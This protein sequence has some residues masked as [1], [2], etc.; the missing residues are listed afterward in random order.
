MA[1]RIVPHLNEHEAQVEAFNQRIRAGGRDEGFYVR[2]DLEWI[3]P[4]PGARAWREF[5]VAIDDEQAVRGAFALKPQDWLIKGELKTVTDWQ[6]PV[7]EGIVDPRF[8]AVGLRMLRHMVKAR[9]LLYSQGHG[10]DDGAVVQ[11]LKEMGWPLHPMPFCFLVV[12]PRA[13]LR[14]NRFLRKDPRKAMALD[15][16]AFSG[17]GSLGLRALH[18]ALRTRAGH[19]LGLRPRYAVEPSFGPWADEVWE[20]NRGR[21]TALAVRDAEM[22][23]RL[24]PPGGWPAGERLRVERDG[25]TIGWA[26][27]LHQRMKD[28]PRFGN[29]HVGNVT[30]MFAAPE[31]AP[32]VVAAAVDHLRKK[33]VEFIYSNVSH[34]GWA[35]GFEANGFVVLPA[36]RLF[37]MAPPLKEAL[38]PLAET[39]QGLHL[40]N[41][42]GHGPQ[43]FK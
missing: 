36:K 27:V 6:G 23:N 13:F 18:L 41:L 38:E 12:R 29:M 33:S 8:G 37:A 30:D 15:A 40:T 19:P 28:E 42:D 20:Q 14:K 7:S 3:P 17:L 2:P 39:T 21:Y 25:K 35:K 9:P 24:C 32:L 11:L 5:Y 10:G 34:P 4:T 43:D 26:F 31:D 16:L 1:I 22:M